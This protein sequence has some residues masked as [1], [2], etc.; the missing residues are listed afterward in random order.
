MRLAEF[1]VYTLRSHAET[2]TRL[3]ALLGE[4]QL[5]TLLEAMPDP[6]PTRKLTPEIQSLFLDPAQNQV[7]PDVPGKLVPP[8]SP[9]QEIEGAVQEVRLPV[10]LEFYVWAY[11]FYRMFIE[12]PMDLNSLLADADDERTLA[13]VDQA[14]QAAREWTKLLPLPPQL[15]IRADQVVKT[16][17]IKF[18]T[19]VLRALGK[20]PMRAIQAPTGGI[21]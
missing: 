13:L 4:D 8:S 20:R 9:Y 18:R 11:P 6:G 3:A 17:W 10:V 5:I 1:L 12:S 2:L 14:I 16:P 21:R 15:A 19:D 7:H